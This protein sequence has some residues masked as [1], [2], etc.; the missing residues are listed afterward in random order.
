MGIGMAAPYVLLSSSKKL[1]SLLPKPGRW[2]DDFKRAMGFL[3]IVFAVNLMTSLD[4]RLTVTTVGICL[5]ILCAASAHKRYAPFGTPAGRRVI[6]ISSCLLL[7]AIGTAV[8]VKSL[9]L[10]IPAFDDAGG[11]ADDADGAA[12]AA[13]WQDFSPAALNA[14]HG[15]G[16]NAV[17][18]FTAS[19]CTSCKVNKAAVIDAAASRELYNEKNILLLTADITNPNPQ[20]ESLLH[21]LGSRSI[22]LLAIFPADSPKNPIIMRDVL[23]KDKYLSVLKGLP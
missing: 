14:A 19:W 17:V 1:F 23:S 11:A 3:L 9:R 10:A 6:V 20:A 15:E 18:N 2:I 12:A 5:S 16:R 13:L 8:S 22:P 7:M 21:H 4:P